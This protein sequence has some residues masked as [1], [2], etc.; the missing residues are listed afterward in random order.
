MQLTAQIGYTESRGDYN[1]EAGGYVGKY[2]FSVDDLANL[3]YLKEGLQQAVDT[4]TNPN[5]WANKDNVA[6]LQDF[7]NSPELQEQAMFNLLKNNYAVLQSTGAIVKNMT[8]DVIAGLLSVS[9]LAGPTA[10]TTWYKTG[11]Y[12]VNANGYTATDY[13]NRGKFST[14]QTDVYGL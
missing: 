10:A 1:L 9:H 3:G 7:L 11:R 8:N 14:T 2:Q 4:I 5:N 13:Y 6:N 12:S